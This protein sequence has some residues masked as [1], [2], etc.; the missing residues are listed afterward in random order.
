MIRLN[1][2]AS[3]TIFALGSM[4]LAQ[5][6]PQTKKEQIHKGT[7]T[8]TEKASGTVMAVEGNTLVMKMSTGEVRMFTPPPDLKYVID[9]K[10]M[11]INELKPGMKLNATVTTTK[12]SVTERTTTVGSGTVWWVAGNY[13]ILTLPNGENREYKVKEDY[14]F[15][16]DGKPATVQDLRK[17]MKVQAV[18]IVEEPA[19]LMATDRRVTGTMPAPQVAKAPAAE[20]P[21]PP[22][23]RHE[24]APTPEPRQVA[25]SAPPP[26][27]VPEPVQSQPPSKLPETASEL[28]LIGFV[29]LLCCAGAWA[30]RRLRA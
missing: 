5:E 3:T 7:A 2:I 18:R 8:T 25:Q 22:A 14:K 16:I 28:P 23:P 17:G 12:T 11:T 6:M 9:G 20:Q 21:R 29:G 13:V 26:V 4:L 24:P 15:I 30:L 10:E 27:S 19:V 1:V